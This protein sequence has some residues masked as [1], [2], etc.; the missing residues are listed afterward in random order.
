VHELVASNVVPRRFVGWLA[1]SI[2]VTTLVGC[3]RGDYTPPP[4][5]LTVTLL[6]GG[7]PQSLGPPYLLAARSVPELKAL[8]HGFPDVRFH[9]PDGWDDF[10]DRQGEVFLA[11]AGGRCR[12]ITLVSA[13]KDGPSSILIDWKS[14]YVCAQGSGSAAT[15][16]LFLASMPREQLGSGVVIFHLSGG[17]TRASVDLS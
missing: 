9:D 4:A 5:G 7:G 14:E 13:T 11:L 3:Q 16:A 1:A 6:S 17:S 10:A 15:P 8:L 12:R 2:L